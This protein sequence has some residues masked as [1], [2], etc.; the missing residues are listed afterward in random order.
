MVPRGGATSDFDRYSP[1]LDQKRRYANA[2]MPNDQFR[3]EMMKQFG[4]VNPDCPIQDPH[5][6]IDPRPNGGKGGAQ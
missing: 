2:A 5:S 4:R 6:P 3:K 1:T